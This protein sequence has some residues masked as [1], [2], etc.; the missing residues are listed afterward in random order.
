MIREVPVNKNPHWSIINIY[1]ICT[2]ILLLS[3]PKEYYYYTTAPINLSAI[4]EQQGLLLPKFS[5]TH[6]KLL[7]YFHHFYA[8]ITSLLAILVLPYLFIAQLLVQIRT[9][10]GIVP[11]LFN[12]C[13]FH[14]V[15]SFL[16]HTYPLIKI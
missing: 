9:G 12:Q 2:I 14:A 4:S 11:Y 1:H 3:R 13:P 15:L 8:Y 16:H 6:L 7:S 10:T 5:N